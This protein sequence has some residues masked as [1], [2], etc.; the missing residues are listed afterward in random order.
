MVFAD[1]NP[2]SRN[3]KPLERNGEK[4]VRLHV[5]IPWKLHMRICSLAAKEWKT[6]RDII[7]A[8]LQKQFP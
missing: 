5:E 2:V 6:K 1:S 8:A 7:I 3:T 4:L